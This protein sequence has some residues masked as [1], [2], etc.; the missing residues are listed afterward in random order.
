M[1]KVDAKYLDYMTETHKMLGRGGLL[2]A[3]ADAQGK[4]NAMT[5]GWGTIGFSWNRPIFCVLV[6]PQTYTYG[7][8][9]TTNDFTVN[10]PTPALKDDVMYFG[11]VS[12]RDE[13]K[14]K[15]RGLTATPGRVVTSPIIEECVIHYECKVVNKNDVLPDNLSDEIRDGIYGRLK[16]G[17]HRIY[18]GEILAVYADA[19][20]KHVLA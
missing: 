19:D 5:I 17:F 20:A 13:D 7:L 14:F 12:G 6:R 3:S 10:I 9:E 16:I 4:P 15:V 11:T 1:E 18:F 2:L 8:I